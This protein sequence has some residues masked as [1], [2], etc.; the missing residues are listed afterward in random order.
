MHQLVVPQIPAVGCSLQSG[1]INSFPFDP[2]GL[3]SAKHAVNEVKNGRLA[4]VSA[5][6]GCLGEGAEGTCVLLHLASAA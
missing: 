4:M 1:F 6:A 3:N 2:V 5:G